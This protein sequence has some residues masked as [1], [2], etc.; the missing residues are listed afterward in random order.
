MTDVFKFQVNDH[1]WRDEEVLAQDI[2]AKWAKLLR[3]FRG[4]LR[5]DAP[6]EDPGPYLQRPEA[7]HRGA[8]KMTSGDT[9]QVIFISNERHKGV[10]CRSIPAGKYPFGEGYPVVGPCRDDYPNM[11]VRHN[12][13]GQIFRMQE[14]AADA[15][16]AAEKAYGRP[17]RITGEAW[18]SCSIQS[19][20]YRS[21][22]GRFANPDS[23]R[24]CRGLAMDVY[25]SSANLN[26]A[27]RAALI[28]VGFS[29]PVSGEPWH[30]CYGS[31][32]G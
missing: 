21:D 7:I 14:P 4:K 10:R 31:N 30:C 26:T 1:P 5:L 28:A 8:T 2:E 11:V 17:I 24:H 22:P 6:G 19:A 13:G 16:A 25:N 27:S 3:P 29:F 20:L 15:Y 18:R 32:P 9:G 23:S 12:A